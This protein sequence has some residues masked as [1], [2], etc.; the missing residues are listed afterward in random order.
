MTYSKHG[1]PKFMKHKAAADAGTAMAP[2][3]DKGKKPDKAFEGS[4]VT[5]KPLAGYYT[6]SLGDLKINVVNDG[7]FHL[8]EIAPPDLEVMDTLAMNVEEET[9]QAYFRSHLMDSGDI[10][11][12][13][14]PILIESKDRRIL[15]DSGWSGNGASPTSGRL[16]SSLA[17]LG[18]EPESI[19]TIILT[20]A[21]PDHLGGLLNPGSKDLTYP[22][23]EVIISQ[24]EFEFWSGDEGKAVGEAIPL[25]AEAP[26]ILQAIDENLRIIQAGDEIVSG[27]QSIPSPGHTPGH[28]SLGIEAGG[29]QLLLTGDAITNT[30]TNFEHPE[31]QPFFEHDPEQAGRTRRKLLDRAATDQMLMLGYHFPF[32]GLGYALSKGQ[33]YQWYPAGA[34]LLP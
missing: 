9:R 8:S 25:L 27:I 14:S 16:A 24:R 15:V 34:T 13:V 30:H 19:D 12:L 22:N 7:Y 18:I 32:P 31:W 26:G 5:S 28:I 3:L 10:R 11:L 33:A 21:H 2:K 4:K 17:L 1:R 6:F 20:H 29:K 23:A